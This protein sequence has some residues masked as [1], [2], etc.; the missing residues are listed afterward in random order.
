MLNGLGS[1]ISTNARVR[2]EGKKADTVLLALDKLVRT[3][4]S[5]VD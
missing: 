3:I 4:L 5:Y 1:Y 2:F